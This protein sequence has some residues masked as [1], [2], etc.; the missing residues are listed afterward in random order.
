MTSPEES[1]AQRFA[2]MLAKQSKQAFAS[3]KE[4]FQ[5]NGPGCF[6]V[7][8]SGLQEALNTASALPIFYAAGD[9]LRQYA[10]NETW[11]KI[12]YYDEENEFVFVVMFEDTNKQFSYY[13]KKEYSEEENKHLPDA[14]ISTEEQ[15]QH[16][17][18]FRCTKCGKEGDALN[19]Y[20]CKQCSVVCYCDEKC[21]G[22]DE[23]RHQKECEMFRH[24]R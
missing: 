10:T 11:D 24:Q 8:F 6:C 7:R 3:A 12:D 19:L 22:E 15:T 20:R 2:L 16:P 17:L 9:A 21:A 18:T 5:Q 14:R 1:V 4:F 23:E 13:V